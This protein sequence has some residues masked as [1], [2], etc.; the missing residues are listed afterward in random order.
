MLHSVVNVNDTIWSKHT[1]HP[2]SFCSIEGVQVWNFVKSR[3]LN[4]FCFSVIINKAY[5]RAATSLCQSANDLWV[6]GMNLGWGFNCYDLYVSN[7]QVIIWIVCCRYKSDY[8][9]AVEGMKKHLIRKSEPSKLTYIGELTSGRNFSPKMVSG[10]HYKGLW[11][12]VEF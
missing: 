10:W 1:P 3:F 5:I 12:Y 4:I 2:P 7:C 8:M 6:F 9:E 11:L